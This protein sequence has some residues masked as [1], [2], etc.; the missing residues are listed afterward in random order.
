MYRPRYFNRLRPRHRDQS[1][2]DPQPSNR[3][4]PA[5]LYNNYK[6][7]E[8]SQRP[9]VFRRLFR[10][11]CRHQKLA[12]LSSPRYTHFTYQYKTFLLYNM[13]YRQPTTLPKGVLSQRRSTFQHNG[14]AIRLPRRRLSALPHRVLRKRV[15]RTRTQSQ[16]DVKFLQTITCDSRPKRLFTSVSNLAGDPR[17]AV[18][19]NQKATRRYIQRLLLPLVPRPVQGHLMATSCTI[20]AVPI[21][22]SHRPILLPFRPRP[23]RPIFRPL[24]SQTTHRGYHHLTSLVNGDPHHRDARLRV[25]RVST[26]VPV[27]GAIMRCRQS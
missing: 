4:P 17:H 23:V 16:G 26:T 1:P 11:L 7:R 12:T 8:Q 10:M 3:P 24:G 22:R 6:S 25:V 13:F 15:S 5:R 9:I 27:T 19:G 2:S 14:P 21:N 20:V 18:H